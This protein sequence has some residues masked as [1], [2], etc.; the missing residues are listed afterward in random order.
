MWWPKTILLLLYDNEISDRKFIAWS[1]ENN[2]ILQLVIVHT[3]GNT[4]YAI[5]QWNVWTFFTPV[6]RKHFV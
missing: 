4:L 3:S 1:V 6:F 5:T 2:Q